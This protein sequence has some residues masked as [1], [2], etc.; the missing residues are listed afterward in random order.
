MT[1]CNSV[2]SFTSSVVRSHLQSCAAFEEHNYS[3]GL[4]ISWT[5]LERLIRTEWER[6]LGE[7]REREKD[8][9]GTLFINADR[10]KKLSSGRDF[11]ASVIT[12]ILSLQGLMS[13]DIYRNIQSL[14]TSRNEWLH[15]LGPV[16]IDDCLLS[17]T[18]C[19]TL[20]ERVARVKINVP[21]NASHLSSRY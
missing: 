12:E 6:Y 7:N 3:L 9:D 8:D 20:F 2:N 15:A 4:V 19:R 21:L 13:F 16:S 11:T 17:I 18:A 5:I 10:M 1:P 14:R